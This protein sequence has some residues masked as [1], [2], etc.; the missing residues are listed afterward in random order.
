M[1]ALLLLFGLLLLAGCGYEPPAQTDRST[2]AYR[3]DLDACH[4]QAATGVNQRNAKTGLAW[5]SS[6]VRR[7]GQIDDAVQGCMAGKG[8]GQL[9]WC[10]AE[11]QRA[12]T[13]SGNVVVTAS[14]LRCSD[15]PAPERRRAG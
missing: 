1:R 5:F 11:E 9:R 14:G 7:W 10:S 6:P 15:P 8:Y 4:D 13:R 2:P 3:A 12:G